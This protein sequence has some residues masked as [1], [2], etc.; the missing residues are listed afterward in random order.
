MKKSKAR[1]DA[2][3]RGF[4]T[5]VPERPC[6]RGHSLRHTSTGKCIECKRIAE[7]ARIAKNREA[8]NARK[9]REREGKKPELAAKMRDRRAAESPE[10]RAD[11][12]AKGRLRVRAWRELNPDH[13]GNKAAKRAYKSTPQ[14]RAAS[15]SSGAKAAAAKMNRTPKW[16]TSDDLWVIKQ[17]YKLAALRTAMFGFAWHVDHIIPLQGK[18]VSGLHVPNNLQ[19]I[20]WRDNVLKANKYT[21]T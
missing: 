8:Y 21:P 4:A 16:L 9:A 5:Y 13:A 7:N 15:R 11:R 3:E 20:P 10:Q 19:V 6:A 17:A 2:K 18:L 14:G 1:L 12:L